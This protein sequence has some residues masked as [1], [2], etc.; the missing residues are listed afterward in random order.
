MT[1]FFVVLRLVIF[2]PHYFCGGKA[3]NSR[4]GGYVDQSF[5]SHLVGD[6]LYLVGGAL[7]APDDAA[8]DNPI[9]PVK[10][11]K[12]V[13]L[14]RKTYSFNI[15]GGRSAVLYNL[16]DTVYNGIPPVKGFL[17]RVTVAGSI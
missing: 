17:F 11:Y 3:G 10:H 7:V 4:V 6:L 1:A 16:S 5:R 14:S 13:H 9:V 8:A 15:H 12:T 2:Y